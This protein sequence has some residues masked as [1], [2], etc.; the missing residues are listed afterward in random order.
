MKKTFYIEG[1]TCASCVNHVDKSVRKVKGVEDVN[2]SL[3][4]NSME[5]DYSC[6]D[7]DIITAVDNAGYKAFLNKTKEKKDYSLRNLII[8]FS[9]L[10][11]LMY[12]SMGHMISLPLPPFL[13]GHE[14][15]LYFSLAQLILTLPIVIIYHHF[16]VTG[17]KRLIKLSPNMD[18]LIAIGATASLV[19][20]VFAIIMIGIGLSNNNHELVMTYHES[21]YFE[22]A[23]MIL[24]LVS[25]GKYLE[26]KSKKRTTLAITKLMDLA[27]KKA[28]LF[29]NNEEKVVP[30]EEV[31]KGDILV[32]KKGEQ[33]PVD[34]KIIYGTASIDQS[35]IT[36]E[37]LPV[38]KNVNDRVFS[39]T[40]ISSGY[41]KIEAEKV[42]ED[43]S[44][45]NIIRLVKEA[46]DSKAPISKLVDKVS[47]IFVPVVMG[48]SILTLVVH[49]IISKNFESSFN[50]AISVLVV[51]CP[52]ALGLATPVAIMVGTGKGAQCGLLIKNAEIL[53]KAQYI[54]TIVLD[55][56]G[57][58]TE[59]KPKVTDVISYD[60]NLLN[61]AYSLEYYSEHPLSN[62]ITSYC[63]NKNVN[64]LKIN[65]FISLEGKGLKGMINEEYYYAGNLKLIKELKLDNEEL[66]QLYD[67]LSFECKTP[68]IFASS[69]KIL[70]II[71]V[72]DM[73]K[74]SS[75]E[76]I[77]ELKK[78][79]IETIMLTGD[80]KNIASLV[81]KQ[82][83]IDKVYAEV[84]PEDKQQVIKSLKKDSHHLVSMV[85]D[86]VNDALALTSADLGISIGGG[87]D[88]AKESS[89]IVL[90]R[91]DL[92]DVK[93]IILLSKR[94]FLTIKVNLF[95]A[96]FYNCIGIV[97]ATGL[98]EPWLHIKLNP[99]LSSLMMSISSVFVVVNALTINLLKIGKKENKKMKNIVL[100]VEGM[101]CNHCKKHVEDALKSVG[102]VTKV[103]VSLEKKNATIECN[104]YVDVETLI[105]AV[106]K[107]GYSCKK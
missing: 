99:M 84:F 87:S 92:E 52:C 79:G 49:L 86:G 11:L 32:I 40:I 50:Y 103:E 53:E 96:F 59:G 60:D 30:L 67:K 4:T 54:K 71:A 58:L 27:P 107:E 51:A 6:D 80:N 17:F 3:L 45:A 81:A 75:K 91:N 28:T 57:T 65:N 23:A 48:I 83:G 70:G 33:V 72:S 100:N 47:G 12:V 39:S 44:I 34:G 20:G 29:I 73:L 24:T 18:S 61:I 42:G 56:T 2:V 63:E 13:S 16:F 89:D 14:N 25:F 36:G 101:M 97:L 88:I 5:V 77:Q 93:N 21:L 69:K 19:Y 7:K 90:L 1:M 104:D 26:N 105:E 15:T 94:V 22:S 66:I 85:G 10:I 8:A 102:G 74:S 38:V 95:W 62:A 106:N 76:A 55:K 31:K 41:I 82:V 37:S 64:L 35:N 46:S 98:L 78:L 43:T 9:F 68:L